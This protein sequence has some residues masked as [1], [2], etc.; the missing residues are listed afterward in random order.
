VEG[1]QLK[2][3]GRPATV[4]PVDKQ[5]VPTY[6]EL[7]VIASEDSLKDSRRVEIY[8]RFL[9]GLAAGTQAAVSSPATA[10]NALG[11][12]APDLIK[13]AS[14]QKFLKASLAV[15]LPVLKKQPGKP[16]GYMSP[17]EWTT[18]GQ[19]MHD[20]GLLKQTGTNYAEALT[21]DLLPGV[22]PTDSTPTNNDDTGS[23]NV[24]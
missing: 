7:V 3:D 1:V 23:V 2:I 6:D 10:Y 5:G 19:W 12:A 20:N 22:G 15:T 14:A 8:R 24:K 13:G 16:F 17:A 21:T 18:Y 11:A 4:I 9:A